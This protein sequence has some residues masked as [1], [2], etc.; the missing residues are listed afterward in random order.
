MAITSQKFNFSVMFF[1]KHILS[2]SAKNYPINKEIL[3]FVTIQSKRHKILIRSKSI[4]Y[5]LTHLNKKVDIH[6]PKHIT[7]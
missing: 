3:I 7:N 2:I 6:Y 1:L 5:I 4:N